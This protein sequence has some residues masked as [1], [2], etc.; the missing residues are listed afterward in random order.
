MTTPHHPD[1]FDIAW[2]FLLACLSALAILMVAWF[3]KIST[4]G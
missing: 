2:Y 3:R 4:G 1:Y